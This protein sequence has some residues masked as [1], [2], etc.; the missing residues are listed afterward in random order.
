MKIV[1]VLVALLLLV[2]LVL[3]SVRRAKRGRPE[4]IASAAERP[5]PRAED[6]IACAHC[7]VHLPASL[8]LVAQGQAYC[9][10]PHREAGPRA[11]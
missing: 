2:W 5:A 3:G 7:G 1:V 10:E 6:M 4:G 11:P 9:S 8:A